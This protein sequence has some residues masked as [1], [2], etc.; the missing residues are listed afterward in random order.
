M[1]RKFLPFALAA[2]YAA[3]WPVNVTAAIP[4]PTL[5]MGGWQINT[6]EVDTNWQSGAF[7]APVPVLLVR[8][9]ARIQADRATGNFKTKQAVLS[10]NVRV[11][12][13]SGS[14]TNFGGNHKPSSLTCD[15]LQVDGVSKIYVAT[16]NV[17]FRQ[18]ASWANADRAVMNGNSHDLHLYGHVSLHQ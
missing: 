17:H 11:Y 16:G 7:S 2:L 9:G 1:K 14:L 18:G 3:L 15:S 4:Q 8:P 13:E 6:G 10:G 5:G 12:D